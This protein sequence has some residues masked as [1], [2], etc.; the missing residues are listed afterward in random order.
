MLNFGSGGKNRAFSNR[1]Q[2][3]ISVPTVTAIYIWCR[4]EGSNLYPWL[5]RPPHEPS[6]LQ[7]HFNLAG[8]KDFASNACPFIS[9]PSR[10]AT[11]IVS[12]L[13]SRT[14]PYQRKKLIRPSHAS[15]VEGHPHD[16]LLGAKVGFEPNSFTFTE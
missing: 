7:R 4:R 8:P 10:P 6:L 16:N 1:L 15:C 5:F 14:S 2:R 11:R 12:S 3:T 9:Y 13:V